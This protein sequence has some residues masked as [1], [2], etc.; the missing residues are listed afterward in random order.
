MVEM[1]GKK[2]VIDVTPKKTETETPYMFFTVTV[3]N[4]NK[5]KHVLVKAES[6]LNALQYTQERLKA[7]AMAVHFTEYSQYLDSQETEN[8]E[9]EKP[10]EKGQGT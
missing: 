6:A 9:A 1:I 7:P 4:K 2:E 3:A 5:L 10:V 8:N